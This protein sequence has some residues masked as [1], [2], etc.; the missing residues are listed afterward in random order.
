MHAILV[1]LALTVHGQSLFEALLRPCDQV[2][3]APRSIEPTTALEAAQ[4]E[5]VDA[6]LP[7]VVVIGTETCVPCAETWIDVSKARRSRK[8]VAVKVDA[9]S[10]DGVRLRGGVA[11]IP[12][13]ITYRRILG[14]W[15]VFHRVGRR[16]DHEIL[17][18]VDAISNFVAPR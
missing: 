12:H 5:A 3:Q 17:S 16:R 7:L 13:V 18:D 4:L 6:D 10:E 15:Y 1:A 14:K 8:F 11:T 9:N 2:D